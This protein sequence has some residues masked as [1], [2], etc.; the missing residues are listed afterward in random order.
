MHSIKTVLIFVLLYR[1]FYLQNYLLKKM[2]NAQGKSVKF[3]LQC[4]LVPANYSVKKSGLLQLTLTRSCKGGSLQ[5]LNIERSVNFL[6][7]L[8]HWKVRF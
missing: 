5:T 1:I 8:V 4:L 6:L 7:A 3:E 2:E